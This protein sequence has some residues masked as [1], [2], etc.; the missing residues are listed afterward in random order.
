MLRPPVLMRACSAKDRARKLGFCDPLDQLP[1]RPDR[2]E[3]LQQ[4]RPHQP[5][6]RDRF[7]SDRRM[8]RIKIWDSDF[9]AA[10]TIFQGEHVTT[11]P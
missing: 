6:W 2:V 10:C 4:Q 3:G 11:C 7:P 1:L 5:L 9:N 8:Q